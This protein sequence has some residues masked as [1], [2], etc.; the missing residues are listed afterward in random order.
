MNRTISNG[1]LIIGLIS[2]LL[3]LSLLS[4]FV[5]G[6]YKDE[7][8]AIVLEKR[9]AIF[10]QIFSNI[11]DG[12]KIQ[13]KNISKS[14]SDSWNQLDSLLSNSSLS[15]LMQNAELTPISA[16]GNSDSSEFS[17]SNV[18]MSMTIEFGER[19][20]TF[21]QN[22]DYEVFTNMK[23]QGN[24]E[25]IAANISVLEIIKRII[26][27]ILISILVLL[28]ILFTYLVFLRQLK[29]ERMLSQMRN[30]FMSNMS[31]ELK[32][33][34]STISVALEALS[35]FN[36]SS[37]RK[38]SEEYIK[39]S[40]HEINRL[41]MLVDKALNISL[42]EQGKFIADKQSLDIHEEINAIIKTLKVQLDSTKVNLT[43]HQEGE[44]FIL[45]ADKT[46]I[47][48]VIH[49][50]IE[51][52]IKYSNKDPEINIFLSELDGN[53]KL[54]ITDNG[55][56]ISLENQ[57]KIFDKF[58]RVSQG[59]T[60][61]TKG[62]GLGLSYVKEVINRHNGTIDVKSQENKGSTFTITLP[63]IQNVND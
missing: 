63:K 24:K 10:V 31:H 51:N 41:G 32:T 47:V 50:L 15:D 29:K 14:I 30:D 8:A 18:D 17:N 60:H 48:N 57:D 19:D 53:I 27:Q 55:I 16:R 62:H 54:T 52:A 13:D 45:L 35:N 25:T 37:N 3:T 7:K 43:Y 39:I 12:V 61:D 46:H 36:A 1:H 9:D 56:G 6:E 22:I 44:H 4:Y 42:Y 2:L 11:E 20:K 58:Y 33:P 26:P 49:N 5:I 23:A 40:K 34:V 38:M 59:N 28:S 21:S